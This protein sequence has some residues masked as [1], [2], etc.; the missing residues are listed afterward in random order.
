MDG[1]ERWGTAAASPLHRRNFLLWLGV[2]KPDMLQYTRRKRGSSHRK[3][4][5]HLLGMALTLG[6]PRRH[7]KVGLIVVARELRREGIITVFIGN[8]G[9]NT[10]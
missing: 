6:R 3:G 10:N 8:V 9:W 2:G 1:R 7:I 5:I 4:S